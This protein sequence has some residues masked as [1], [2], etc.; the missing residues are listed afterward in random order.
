MASASSSARRNALTNSGTSSGIMALARWRMLPV[1]K[2]APRAF[3]AFMILSASSISVGMKRSAMDIIMAISW[4][5]K[6][7]TVSGRISDSRPSVSEMGEVVSVRSWD[8]ITSRIS[9]TAMKLAILRPPVVMVKIQKCT[10]T[11]PVF[12][13]NRLR[14]NVNMMMK[15]IGFNPLNRNFRRTPVDSAVSSTNAAISANPAKPLDTKTTAISAMVA[16]SFVR[17]S[18]LCT[19]E[20]PGKYW[21]IVTLLSIRLY[22]PFQGYR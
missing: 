4:A 8:E 10:S 21:P 19:K 2:F 11:S 18:S 13:K 16:S 17:G 6:W 14:M 9:R 15:K 22:R 12:W 20:F 5:G 7:T 3:W 1:S